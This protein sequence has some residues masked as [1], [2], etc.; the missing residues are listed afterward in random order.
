ME[1]GPAHS[2]IPWCSASVQIRGKLAT[3]PLYRDIS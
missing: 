2:L 3:D 1:V